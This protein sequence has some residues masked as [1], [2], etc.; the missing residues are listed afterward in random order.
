MAFYF[1]GNDGQAE[2]PSAFCF[3]FH[4]PYFTS[5]FGA[6]YVNVWKGIKVKLNVDKYQ[7]GGSL[8]VALGKSY[9]ISKAIS[10]KMAYLLNLRVYCFHI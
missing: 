5:L 3:S 1:S 6:R 10:M 2:L 9:R 7:I 8:F 4:Y